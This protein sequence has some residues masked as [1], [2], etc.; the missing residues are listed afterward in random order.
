MLE[1]ESQW[2]ENNSLLCQWRK[3]NT[4]ECDS[5]EESKDE[6]HRYWASCLWCLKGEI[7]T[8]LDLKTWESTTREH[9]VRFDL[10]SSKIKG[11]NQRG[12][13]FTV[14]ISTI[15]WDAAHKIK[16]RWKVMAG[17]ETWKRTGRE[18]KAITIPK[19]SHLS[20]IKAR[21]CLR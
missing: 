4:L 21:L 20:L 12:K 18:D 2:H 9:M 5:P 13:T 11:E 14:W 10:Q 7:Q 16:V 19:A 6:F 3:G 17:R 15:W 1:E 8:R